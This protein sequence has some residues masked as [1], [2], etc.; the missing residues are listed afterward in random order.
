MNTGWYEAQDY[1]YEKTFILPEK[2]KDEKVILN[3][4]AF[5]VRQLY[6]STAKKLHIILMAILVSM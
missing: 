2:A 6:I 5:T 1:T 3:L 4:R